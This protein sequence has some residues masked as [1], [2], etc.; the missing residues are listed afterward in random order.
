[1]FTKGKLNSNESKIIAQQNIVNTNCIK[2]K[3]LTYSEIACIDYGKME[4]K[5]WNSGSYHVTSGKAEV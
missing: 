2:S 5:A 4:I 1:M 3:F